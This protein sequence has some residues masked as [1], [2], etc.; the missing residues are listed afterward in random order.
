MA[1]TIV[2]VH[3]NLNNPYGTITLEELMNLQQEGM[4]ETAIR[5]LEDGYVVT[6]NVSDSATDVENQF[7]FDGDDQVMKVSEFFDILDG[8]ENGTLK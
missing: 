2:S 7:I 6:I 1:D 4:R 3:M 8:M 5:A